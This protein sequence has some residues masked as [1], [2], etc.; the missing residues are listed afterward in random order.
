[1]KVID[2]RSGREVLLGERIDYG[3]GEWIRLVD[4]DPGLFS[5]SAVVETCFVD[6]SKSS[7]AGTRGSL[8]VVE[9]GPLVQMTQQVPLIVR[10]F[11][12]RFFGQHVAFLPT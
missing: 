12:P 10:W 1:M 7:F 9:K 2:A 11:H 6:H 8:E 5:A 3:D 4:V